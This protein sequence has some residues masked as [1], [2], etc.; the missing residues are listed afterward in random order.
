VIAGTLSVSA[1]GDWSQAAKGSYVLI[2]GGTPHSFE[3]RGEVQAGFISF[4]TPGGFEP[5][6]PGI[7]EAMSTVDLGMDSERKR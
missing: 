6:V 5:R 4:N 1:H 3:N 7:A 2:P